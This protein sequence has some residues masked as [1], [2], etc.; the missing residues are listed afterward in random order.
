MLKIDIYIYTHIFFI[1]TK[2]KPKQSENNEGVNRKETDA[3]RRQT[4]KKERGLE[5]Y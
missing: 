3:R 1:K 4:R 5:A 2:P